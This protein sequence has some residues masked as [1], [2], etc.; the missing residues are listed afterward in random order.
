[1]NRKASKR[2]PRLQPLT[3]IRQTG[4]RR[5][6]DG[7]VQYQFVAEI[8]QDL[9]AIRITMTVTPAL[10]LGIQAQFDEQARAERDETHQEEEQCIQPALLNAS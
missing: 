7:T 5:D 9:P 3:C 2:P 4:T 6:P 10:S 8:H 1:M